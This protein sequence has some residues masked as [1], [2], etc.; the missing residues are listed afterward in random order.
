MLGIN[1]IF[2]AQDDTIEGSMADI[3]VSM[4]RL[5]VALRAAAPTARIGVALITAG[6][7]SQ[8]AFGKN[9]TCRQTRWQYRKNQHRLNKAMAAKFADAN[10]CA[11]TL[12]PACVN[13]DCVNNFPQVT[14]AINQDNPEQVTRLNNGVHPASTGYN[15]I[16]DTFFCWLMAQL[17]R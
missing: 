8:D 13:L 7:G 14:E 5:L 6:A 3:F 10:P 2:N 12:I 1:D 15:Q 17:A 9:Y 16:G 4:D 11:I